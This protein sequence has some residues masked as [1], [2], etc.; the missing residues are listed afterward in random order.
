MKRSTLLVLALVAL[1]ALALLF[2]REPRELQPKRQPR[3]V[4]VAPPPEPEVPV[5]AIPAEPVKPRDPPPPRPAPPPPLALV[6]IPAGDVKPGT[7]RGTVKILGVAPVRK[8]IRMDADPKCERL[9]AG[10]VLHDD[11]LI[12]PA[13]NIRNAFVYVA[14]GNTG[15]APPGP[16]PPVLLDQVGCRFE[17]R[18]LGVQ[19]NQ[20]L[21]IYN[22]DD[23]LHNVH[24]LPVKNKEFNFGLP[25]PGLFQTRRFSTPEVMVRIVCDV[26]PWMRAW[27]GVLDHPYFSVT[28]EA[29]NY[30]IAKLPPGRFLIKVWHERYATVEQ[31]IDVPPGGDVVLNFFLDARKD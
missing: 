11:L 4:A 24:G 22:N 9:H 3:P 23:L 31:E 21:N 19:V 6:K 25:Q 28:G 1:L 17:P 14:R 20:P 27:V 7:I 30:A 16:L 15:A 10:G 26:H 8:K 18:V 13:N 5:A 12:D 29:G 2:H